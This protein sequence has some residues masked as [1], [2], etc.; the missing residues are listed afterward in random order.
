VV[1]GNATQSSGKLAE[2]VL[3]STI[4]IPPLI[5]T[6]QGGVVGVYTAQDIDF[7]GVYALA[8]TSP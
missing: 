5:Y 6:N 3:E 8:P 7:S 2:K 1:L 4:N